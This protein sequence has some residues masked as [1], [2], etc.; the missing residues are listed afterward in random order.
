MCIILV[1]KELTI[2]WKGYIMSSNL[3][4]ISI[5]NFIFCLINICRWIFY[6]HI[7]GCIILS[8]ECLI[9]TGHCFYCIVNFYIKEIVW[10]Y[11]RRIYNRRYHQI[12]ILTLAWNICSNCIIYKRSIDQNILCQ[13][14]VSIYTV[15]QR[16]FIRCL[17]SFK[18]R[19]L[20]KVWEVRLVRLNVTDSSSWGIHLDVKL[21]EIK[22][23][24]IV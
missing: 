13:I 19:Q 22:H 15:F 10:I 4:D 2:Q 14:G 23:Y 20:I 5:K 1:C 12:S 17:Q 7:N 11:W 3:R 18:V 16:I 24:L 6:L 8:F 9:R 21:T